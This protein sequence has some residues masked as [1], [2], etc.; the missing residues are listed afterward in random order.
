MADLIQFRRDTAERWS[1]YNP[2]LLQGELG[3]VT[4]TNNRYKIGDG[5][6]AWNSLTLPLKCS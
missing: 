6:H 1:Q 2:V 3:F 5:V 4:D